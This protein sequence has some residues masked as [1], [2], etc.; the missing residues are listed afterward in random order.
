MFA[1]EEMRI[2]TRVWC[3]KSPTQ[4][5]RQNDTVLCKFYSENVRIV[6]LKHGKIMEKMTYQTMY[7]ILHVYTYNPAQTMCTFKIQC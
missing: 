5:N 4:I 7:S 1:L 6:H 3:H 2:K